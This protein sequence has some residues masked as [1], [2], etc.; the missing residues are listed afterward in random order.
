[1]ED[2]RIARIEWAPLI[3]ERPRAAGCNAHMEPLGP[4]TR[5]PI[6]RITLDDGTS[7]FGLSRATESEL[8]AF[9]GTRISELFKPAVGVTARGL[10]I[11]LPLWDLAGRRADRPVYALTT[12]ITGAP[13]PTAPLR[14]RCYDTTLYID[15]L[16][17]ADDEAG[18]ALMA[19]EARQGW[20]R[21]H[22][23]FKIKIGR[24]N[25][26]MPTI[27]GLRRDIAVVRA[28]RAAVGPDAPIMADANN[29]YTFNIARDFLAGTADAN[30]FWLEEA[31]Y[32]DALLYRRLKAWMRAEGIETLIADGEGRGTVDPGLPD[33]LAGVDYVAQ[34]PY[35]DFARLLDFAREG[36]V[37]VVQQDIVVPGITRWLQIG[38]LLDSWGRR[39]AP[40]HY[41]TLFGNY[42]SAHLAPAVRNFLFVE[43][44]EATTPALAAP[45]Y[46][47]EDGYVVVPPSPGF[48]LELDEERFTRNVR[49]GGFAAA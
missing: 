35:S 5:T 9:V 39:S 2:A 36:V 10:P 24:G 33:L 7:G 45:G 8:S 19:D 13:A 16:A 38:P 37:D 41:G 30:I 29:G 18:A 40:H 23:A 42:A 12:A 15:D 3:G 6:A 25:V 22:R 46:R 17:A 14:V 28:I 32:E 48:G 21:G 4:R 47:M 20:E 43:W 26:H 27:E 31:F 34:A 44:D 11:E 1:M 49:D